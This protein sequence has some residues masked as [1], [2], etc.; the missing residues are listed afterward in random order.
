[1]GIMQ[2]NKYFTCDCGNRIF[3]K[4]PTL[5]LNLSKFTSEIE[6]NVGYVYRCTQCSK[7]YSLNQIKMAGK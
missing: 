7:N 2:S 6:E 5:L 4:E 1:M 3:V